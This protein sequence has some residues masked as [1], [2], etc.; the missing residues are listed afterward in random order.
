[1][2][3]NQDLYNYLNSLLKL[4]KEEKEALIHNDALKVAEIV[5]KKN[6]FIEKLSNN[7]E[8]FNIIPNSGPVIPN[9]VEGTS[10]LKLIEEI[11][12]IQE[13]N[14]LLTKQ[15]LSYQNVLI[16]SIAKNLQNLSNTY[17]SKGSYQKSNNIGLI[18]QEV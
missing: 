16:E 8:N 5:E 7:T 1:M 6:E 13:T 14:L 17:S 9:A 3:S 12:S 4:V 10:L 15:S 2:P 11:N 18:D